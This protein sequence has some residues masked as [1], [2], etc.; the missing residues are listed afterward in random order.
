MSPATLLLVH[1]GGTVAGT[2]E[3][4]DGRT[5]LR[6]EDAW[7]AFGGAIALS[8]SLPLS[9]REHGH[10]QVDPLGPGRRHPLAIDLRLTAL[11]I[12]IHFLGLVIRIYDFN[13]IHSTPVF[14][15]DLRFDSFARDDLQRMLDGI[16]KGHR[17]CRRQLFIRFEQGPS[18]TG[19]EPGQ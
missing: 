3:Q 12:D 10:E 5:T 18:G 11:R 9:K 4:A 19:Y 14:L 13:F 8:L 1:D 17:S 7:R 2:L 15:A 16:L 6:Y